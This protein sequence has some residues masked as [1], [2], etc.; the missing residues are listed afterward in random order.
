MSF[1]PISAED[2]ADLCESQEISLGTVQRVR[3]GVYKG[4]IADSVEWDA[5]EVYIKLYPEER[6]ETLSKFA[7]IATEV[8]HPTCRVVDG[9]NL[10][11]VM[12]LAPG[13]PLSQILPFA[14]VPG[15]WRFKRDAVER[16]YK[17]IGS[18]L[19]RLHTETADGEC[20]ILT[21]EEVS[22]AIDQ[23]QLLTSK[24]SEEKIERIIRLL[25]KATEHQTPK[26]ITYGDRSPHNIYYH[27]GDVT[28]IDSTCKRRGAVSDHTSV[29]LGLRLMVKRL[30]YARS[31]I[32]DRLETAYWA[33]YQSTGIKRTTSK[34]TVSIRYIPNVLSLLEHY[35]SSP[36]SINSKLTQYI[37]P[38]ILYDELQDT[39]TEL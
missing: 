31:T 13:R 7:E 29:L 26:S 19:G 39:I 9:T 35:E 20:P 1:N 3:S 37:D 10:C 6:R 22:E 33:G 34:E 16:A 32:I 14:F 8:G 24:I 25:K 15:V 23:T 17:Q 30:P 21:E 27:D 38:P 11:L 18:Y 2:I 5:S 4:T 36:S 28:L 12:E